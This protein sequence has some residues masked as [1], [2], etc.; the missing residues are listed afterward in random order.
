MAWYDALLP[1]KRATD[2]IKKPVDNVWSFLSSGVKVHPTTDN[3]MSL[4]VV[5]A[6]IH[7]LS[8]AIASMPWNVHIRQG[9]NVSIDY[10]SNLQ[11]LLHD[12]PYQ[13]YDSFT[14][15]QTLMY[16]ALIYGNGICEILRD[17][18]SA[19]PTGFRIIPW[20]YVEVHQFLDDRLV[21]VINDNYGYRALT[22]DDII[23]I[24]FFT[25]DGIIG[26][27]PV[28]AMPDAF[29]EALSQLA[30]NISNFENGARI[31]GYIK[32]PNKLSNTAYER[33]KESWQ[34]KY[35][36]PE[37]AGKTAI[38]EEGAVYEKVA[39]TNAELGL[40]DMKKATNTEIT[41]I[42]RVPPN[43]VN[44]LDRA[45]HNN[46]E[47][48]GL[49]LVKYTLRP[50][51]KK[52]EHEFN[53]K[54]FFYEERTPSDG[55]QR[56]CRMNMDSFLR[57]DSKTRSEYYAAMHRIGVYTI[58]DIRRQEGMNPIG[59]EGDQHMVQGAMVS[60]DELIDR[61]QGNGNGKDN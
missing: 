48:Q 40:S 44:I 7:F 22:S 47:H 46:I 10:E 28:S 5:W 24:K 14:F 59:P 33:L 4:P 6:C 45:T 39:M 29:K 21:Y 12:E 51:V 8:E 23:H 17:E 2:E 26:V 30:F 9:E 56:Y 37:N 41:A 15:R 18:K 43:I 36:G 34:Q 16:W 50:W 25:K 31:G 61:L 32:H 57:A 55:Y 1:R 19:V 52:W 20:N 35:G 3:V 54:A 53:R 13:L 60:I 27:S 58:N 42:F 11:Y 38:L 49:D